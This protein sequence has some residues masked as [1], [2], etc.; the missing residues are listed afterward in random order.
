MDYLFLLLGLGLLLLSGDLL[1]RG[2]VSLARHFRVSTL[3]VG[4]TVVSLGTSAPE[5]FVSLQAVFAD[6]ADFAVGTVI[7]S[8]I[9]NIGLVLG[10]TVIIMPIAV[11]ARSVFFDWPVLMASTI[12][13]Y[14]FIRNGELVHFE[15]II[16]LLLLMAF[17]VFSI[18]NSRRAERKKEKKI[19]D[20]KYSLVI[21]LLIVVASSVGLRFGAVWLVD[22][23]SGIASSFNISDYVIST[24]IVAF[25]TSVPELATSVIAAIKKESDISIGN[26][27]GSNLFNVLGIL[28]ITTAIK[29]IE[30]NEQ[31]LNFDIWYLGGISLLLL[32]IMIPAKRARI[33]RIEGVVLLI[34]YITYI[35][36]IYS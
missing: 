15:G 22:G 7:G 13:F 19:P 29:N 9:S 36:F 24:S 2:G 5:L 21:S 18:L 33:R 32:F 14:F 3:V 4:L 30:I 16:L 12:L 1:V 31:V 28:G 10:L 35:A 11:N 6:K 8:N 20:P 17:L 27:I 25:G 26:I 34:C 23:A